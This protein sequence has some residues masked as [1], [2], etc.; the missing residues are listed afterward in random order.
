MSYTD[1][2]DTRS[3]YVT[4]LERHE[5]GNL[6]KEE[7]DAD[8]LLPG[9]I[10][11]KDGY[12]YARTI[13]SFL[14]REFRPMWGSMVE[15]FREFCRRLRPF[16]DPQIEKSGVEFEHCWDLAVWHNREKL[17]LPEPQGR[18]SLKERV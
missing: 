8:R 13:Q 7:T 12:L 1:S 5:L 17:N 14:G 15:P 2:R 3:W 16:A 4:Q 6:H 11:G 9:L 10:E 18:G